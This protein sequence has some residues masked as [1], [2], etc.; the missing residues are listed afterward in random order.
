MIFMPFSASCF[1]YQSF[2]SS[3]SFQP[4]AS[5]S[6][7]AFSTASCVGLSSASNAFLLTMHRVLRQ[8]GLG[9][10]PVLD[11]LVGL[12]SR[13]R[14]SPTTC[15]ESTTPV[16]S[17]CDS[18]AA[19]TVTGCAPTS[20][21]ILRGRRAVGAPLEALH[22]GDASR[23]A[24]SSRCPAAA[25]APCRAASCPASPSSLSSDRLARRLVELLRVGVAGGEERDAVEAVE[26]VLVLE[27]DEQD[28]ADLRLAA[29]HR[30][31]DLGRLEQRRVRRA[32]VILSLPPVA[33]ST[34]L[35]N[36]CRFS[37]WKLVA[38]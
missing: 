5:A 38:G 33:L 30:A 25:T 7:A 18:S 14:S 9:V 10:V 11:V 4:R 24:S 6:A 31:L 26:R 19:C 3:V 37:V 29:L 8:P 2:F 16:A 28:L 23:S 32:P 1:V 15:S 34:S 35:A 22:V 13:S 17:A 27:V 20:S 21:A 36:C 12:A